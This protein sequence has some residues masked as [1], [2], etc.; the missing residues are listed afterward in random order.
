MTYAPPSLR[1]N[2]IGIELKLPRHVRMSKRQLRF[3]EH[4]YC[5]GLKSAEENTRQ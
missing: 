2:E 3:F 5:L 1:S 4:V